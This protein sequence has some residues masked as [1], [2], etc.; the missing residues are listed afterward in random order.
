MKKPA[1]HCSTRNLK[2]R[3][4]FVIR[5]PTEILQGDYFAFLM[6][7]RVQCLFKCK[8]RIVFSLRGQELNILE[9]LRG[10]ASCSHLVTT[11]P[12]Q[13]VEPLV[14]RQRRVKPANCF[15]SVNKSLLNR[16]L[17]IITIEQNRHRM[18]DRTFLITLDKMTKGF[19]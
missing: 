13:N 16:V 2:M 9:V 8:P 4:E 5:E 18:S 7:E 14:K 12:Q 3:G 15:E 19:P 11:V 10:P 6:R 1:H 17:S